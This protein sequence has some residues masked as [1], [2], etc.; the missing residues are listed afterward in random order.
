MAVHVGYAHPGQ[1][2]LVPAFPTAPVQILSPLGTASLCPSII[3][4]VIPA[5]SHTATCTMPALRPTYLTYQ[6]VHSPA[7]S[8]PVSY[9]TA[10]PRTLSA[11]VPVRQPLVKGGAPPTTISGERRVFNNPKCFAIQYTFKGDFKVNNRPILLTIDPIESVRAHVATGLRVWDGGIVLAKYLEQYVPK[12]LHRT[13]RPQL[14][15]L[16]LGCGTGVAGLSF[17]MMGQQVTLSDIGDVQAELTKGN[18]AQNE[19]NISACGGSAVYE[20]LDWNSLPDRARFGYFDVVFASDVIWHEFLVEPFMKALAWAASGPGLG[21]I[22]L[23]HKVRDQESVT[24]FEQMIAKS[25]LVV[26]SQVQTEASLGPDGHPM[27]S[28]Y[29]LRC[30][31]KK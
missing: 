15:G 10:P 4:A 11:A 6:A 19:G 23:S 22:L 9:T 8:I 21:D 14:R 31:G 30:L 7:A 3:P 18:I 20:T 17:A 28:V 2:Y 12:L 5:I 24:L 26:E 16:E 29:H 13:G 25:G 27:I 1:R